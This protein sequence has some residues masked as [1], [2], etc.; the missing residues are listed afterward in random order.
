MIFLIMGRGIEGCGVTKFSIEFAKY[1]KKLDIPHASF[2]FND[3]KWTRRK[4]HELKDIMQL[5][6]ENDEHFEKF[7]ELIQSKATTVVI[8]SLP[9][10][11]HTDLFKQRFAEI[12]N[13]DKKYILF[14]HD[15]AR[16]SIQRNACLDE[17]IRA[18]DICYAHSTTNYFAE[19]VENNFNQN[20]LES[21]F[22]DEETKNIRVLPFQPAFD[23]DE[24]RKIYW[25]DVKEHD[26]K[27][28]K[29][30]GRTTFWKGF[31]MMF[32]WHNSKLKDNGSVTTFEGI[33]TGIVYPEFVTYSPHHNFCKGFTEAT[34]KL[35]DNKNLSQE[36]VDN[37]TWHG[38]VNISDYDVTK[39]YGDNALVFGIYQNDDM[40]ER[41]SR[42]GFGYQLT[43]LDP[44]NI[45]RSVEYTH[46]EVVATGVIPVFR[47]KFGQA[48]THRSQ[49][50]PL[51]ECENTGTIWLDEENFD[52]SIE[53]VKKLEADLVLRDEWREMAY[54]FYK[55]H[56]DSDN[57]FR[58]IAKEIQ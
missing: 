34:Q 37:Y 21:F 42:S 51:I 33:E 44:K 8:N 20:S 41:M 49:N 16:M 53:L 50:K 18:S 55:D 39:H 13:F 24:C 1:L 35:F 54:E 19:Y 45:E 48:C 12:L 56:Q 4:S 29:W 15:H 32:D 23:F 27:H 17:A 46:C 7:K 58:T 2:A 40:L 5:S 11:G 47:K 52:E 22:S 26:V 30:I 31:Q 14:Q 36:F 28:H 43:M 3:K 10:E 9:S 38:P 25:K 57:V 6:L